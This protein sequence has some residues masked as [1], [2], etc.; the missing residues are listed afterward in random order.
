MRGPGGQLGH[1]PLALVVLGQFGERRDG[2]QQL[3]HQQILEAQ[4]LRVAAVDR[5]VQCEA[6]K[7]LGLFEAGL[8]E[9]VERVLQCV[10]GAVFWFHSSRWRRESRS[11]A[12]IICAGL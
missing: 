4:G 10:G 8:L 3:Q 7:P 9:G 12:E 2:S 6:K 11:A 1:A 5:R